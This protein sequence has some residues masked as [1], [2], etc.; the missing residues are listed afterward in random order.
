MLPDETETLLVFS[1]P[2]CLSGFLNLGCLSSY[3][4]GFPM[5]FTRMVLEPC[6]ASWRHQRACSGI[7]SDRES[8]GSIS[9]NVDAFSAAPAFWG[10]DGEREQVVPVVSHLSAYYTLTHECFFVWEGKIHSVWDDR[11]QTQ[12]SQSSF[13]VLQDGSQ[14]LIELSNSFVFHRILVDKWN[15]KYMKTLENNKIAEKQTRV[16][17]SLVTDFI[18]QVFRNMFSL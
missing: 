7:F 12:T 1:W 11:R 8:C 17:G 15:Y 3:T 2:P 9:I 14:Q 18:Y 10:W 5:C 6:L 16:H 13:S 4:S